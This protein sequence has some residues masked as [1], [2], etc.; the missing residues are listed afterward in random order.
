MHCELKFLINIMESSF[1]QL[2]YVCKFFGLVPYSSKSKIQIFLK[3]YSWISI[4]STIFIALYALFIKPINKNFFLSNVVGTIVFISQIIAYSIIML[5]ALLK[6]STH[7]K[8]FVKFSEIN[9]LFQL[10]LRHRFSSKGFHSKLLQKYLLLIVVIFGSP[11]VNVCLIIFNNSV[12]YSGFFFYAFVPIVVIRVR[13]LQ[14]SIYVDFINTYLEALDRNLFQ[15]VSC[16]V[17]KNIRFLDIDYHE[18]EST[19]RVIQLKNIFSELFS[20]MNLYNKCFGWSF[21]TSITCY[22]FD[23]AVNVY[24]LFITFEGLFSESLKYDFLMTIIPLGVAISMM[25]YTSNECSKHVS[26]F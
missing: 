6:C 4:V 13:I 1:Q 2:I 20:L 19:K 26:Y 17:Y 3:I 12:L 15:T 8:F 18:L 24:W 22:A 5:E 25:C 16:S 10:R 14:A 11:F 21:L 7:Q 9:K 23:V